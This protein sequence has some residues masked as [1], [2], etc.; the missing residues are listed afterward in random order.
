MQ[1]S[2]YMA[3]ILMLLLFVNLRGAFPERTIIWIVFVADVAD[4]FY[5]RIYGPSDFKTV[6]FFHVVVDSI[7]FIAV[8]W[9]ALG[10]NRAW[11]LPV[12]SLHLLGLTAHIA[13]LAGMP[14]FNQVYWAMT[15]IPDYLQLP[16]I[17]IGTLAHTRRFGQIGPYREWR[18]EWRVPGFLRQP[19]TSATAG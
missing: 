12:C 4:L 7:T 17:L 11:P 1:S 15:S 14:S 3:S 5:H 18:H 2:M 6:D 16:I 9:V 19:A 10:A 8:L 13:M